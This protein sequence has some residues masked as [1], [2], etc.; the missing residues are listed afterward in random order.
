MARI[1]DNYDPV[2]VYHQAE[3]E[4]RFIEHE[5]QWAH[6]EAGQYEIRYNDARFAEINQRNFEISMRNKEIMD[7]LV[8]L[9]LSK[10]GLIVL[11]IS[12]VL[13]A[14]TFSFKVI[15]VGLVGWNIF[16]LII[17]GLYFFVTAKT[18]VTTEVRP[19]IRDRAIFIELSAREK[20]YRR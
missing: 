13:T 14:L 7:N 8:K 10:N 9:Y 20:A 3:N 19:E 11:V 15:I 2:G 5:H 17:L 4:R 1:D 12:L 16:I 18:K 6:S